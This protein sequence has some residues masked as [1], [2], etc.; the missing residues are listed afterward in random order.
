MTTEGL[1]QAVSTNGS[2]LSSSEQGGSENPTN[3]VKVPVVESVKEKI[4]PLLKEP[5]FGSYPTPT[6]KL[7]QRYIDEPRQLRVAV[8]GAGISGVLAGI[9]LPPKVPNVKLTIFEKNADVVSNTVDTQSICNS[10]N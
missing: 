3:G 7:E 4:E 5:K 8:V 6:L 2:T 1:E 10:A 9:I